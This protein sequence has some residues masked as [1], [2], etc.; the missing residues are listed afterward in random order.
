M[1]KQNKFPMQ[2]KRPMNLLEEILS[3]SHY[4]KEELYIM[5]YMLK[6]ELEKLN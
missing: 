4:E 3:K 6:M 5:I 1:Q 2:L